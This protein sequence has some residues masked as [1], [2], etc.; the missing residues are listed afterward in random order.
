MKRLLFITLLSLT[1]FSAKAEWVLANV[2]N[3]GNAYVDPTSIKRTGNI[4]RV[5]ELVDYAKPQVVAGMAYQS[6]R[7]L[8]QYDCVEKTSQ[9]LQ[10]ATF[11][12]KMLAGEVVIT[13]T[14]AY[15]PAFVAPGS[16]GDVLLNFACK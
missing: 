14:K 9:L 13:D 10:I 6:D 5:W 2:S 4:V 7:V 12:G 8:R 11:S 3:A 16:N 1:G 15:P